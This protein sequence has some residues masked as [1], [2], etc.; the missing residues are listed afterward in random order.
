MEKTKE[1]PATKPPQE[2]EVLISEV[3]SETIPV[4]EKAI[5]EEKE[6]ELPKDSRI[7]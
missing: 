5:E 6:E 7:F 2:V 3:K 4:D 1:L